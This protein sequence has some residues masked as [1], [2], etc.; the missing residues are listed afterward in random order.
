MASSSSCRNTNPNSPSDSRF[1][2]DGKAP[3]I[4][5]FAP[6]PRGRTFPTMPTLFRRAFKRLFSAAAICFLAPLTS[7][8]AAPPPNILIILS[9]DHS[10]P[11]V[12]CYGNKDVHTPN[13]DALAAQGMRFDRAYTTSP[14]CVPSRAAILTGRHT[15]DVGMTRF[16]AALPND[17]ITWPEILRKEHDY[18][19]GLCGRSFHLAGTMLGNPNVAPHL[20]EAD[21][22]H[23]EKR[24][25][26]VKVAGG[27]DVDDAV[28][29]NE[30]IDQFQEFLGQV[31]SG[32]PFFLQLC[33]HD[34]H[35]PFTSDQLPFK[36]DP[37][38]LTLPP[39]YPDSPE[40]RK[41]LA[42]YYDEVARMDGNVGNV[43]RILDDKKLADNTIV[44]FMGDNGS[45]QYRGKGTLNELGIHVPL[46]VRWPGTVK[47]G[48]NSA[49]IISGEDLGPTFLLATGAALPTNLTGISFLPLLR[50]EPMPQPRT[51]MISERGPHASSL[52]RNSANFDLG[53]VIVTDRYKLIF[54]VTWQLPYQPVDY[55]LD[56]I[57]NVDKAGKLDPKLKEIYLA[58]H[59][60]MFELYD[61]QTDPYEMNNLM[62]TAG[63]KKVE[64]DL[65]G[66]L[67]AWQIQHRDFVPLCVGGNE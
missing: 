45:S 22:P 64:K 21:L 10:A 42:A 61:L 2:D 50:G 14:Q 33:W 66:R 27:K 35:R 39:F 58:D 48:A 9:D 13:L 5:P 40:I 67:A 34:P 43:L 11:H 49:A 8:A 28:L 55:N 19:I 25:H 38:K 16:S 15:I 46:I 30:T 53:R 23:F 60:P 26:Y 7:A 6:G 32:K 24:Y 47:P 52:P 1:E 17:V 29:R 31:P 41:D 20:T 63:S 4:R 59:R 44:V 65:K 3:G 12:G 51:Q 54:N 56:A 57:R 36:H 37:A 18:Y 62:G